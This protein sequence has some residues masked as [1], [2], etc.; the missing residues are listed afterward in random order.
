MDSNKRFDQ[1]ESLL[2]DLARKVDQ[3]GEQIAQIIEVLNSQG[4]AITRQGDAITR[5]GD[6]IIRQGKAIDSIAELVEQRFGDV[7]EQIGDI[8]NI[9]KLSE[10]R[11]AENAQ[12]QAEMLIEIQ[13][14]GK[15]TDASVEAVKLLLKRQENTDTRLDG[16]VQTQLQMLQLQRLDADKMDS[17]ASRLPA[18]ESQEPRIK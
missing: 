15:R 12:Q 6:A 18:L 10:V 16:L 11:H 7:G 17:L 8:I 14:L 3:Q 4:N 13:R 5:Q 2:V 9:L 1:I